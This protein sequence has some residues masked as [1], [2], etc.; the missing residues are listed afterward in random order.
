MEHPVD[1]GGVLGIVGATNEKMG[2]AVAGGRMISGIRTGPE[3]LEVFRSDQQ[4]LRELAHVVTAFPRHESSCI[5]TN[6]GVV[7]R[8]ATWPDWLSR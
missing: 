5:E 8:R 7:A 2:D 3:A 1:E 4:R 6:A